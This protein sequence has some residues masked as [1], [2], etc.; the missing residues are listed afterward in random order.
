MIYSLLLIHVGGGI[1][2]CVCLHGGLFVTVL[3]ASVPPLAC[4]AH[5]MQGWQGPAAVMPR[6]PR[7]LTVYRLTSG[8]LL[9]EQDGG[10]WSKSVG[11]TASGHSAYSCGASRRDSPIHLSTIGRREILA[12]LNDA[13]HFS[14]STIAQVR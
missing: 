8:E 3:R 2:R 7:G 11:S 10:H 6:V 4:R 9:A 14:L 1:F 12:W 5:W 13:L